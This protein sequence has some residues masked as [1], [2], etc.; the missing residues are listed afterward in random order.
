MGTMIDELEVLREKRRVLKAA[1]EAKDT[2]LKEEFEE[3]EKAVI[4]RMLEEKSEGNRGKKASGNIQ[5][6]MTF[7]VADRAAIEAWAKKTGNLQVFTNHLSSASIN[8][9]LAL[10]PKLRTTGIPGTKS[11][12]KITLRLSSL[13]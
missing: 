6:A 13:G 1:F 3:I 5:R 10:Q 7:S 9:L 8:E 2:P 11:F 12:E 4:S